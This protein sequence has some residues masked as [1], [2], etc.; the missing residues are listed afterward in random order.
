MNSTWPTLRNLMDVMKLLK[1]LNNKD[2]KQ[3]MKFF[4]D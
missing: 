2:K 3:R 1:K 4:K